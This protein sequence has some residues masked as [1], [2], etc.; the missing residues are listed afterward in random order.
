VTS[1]LVELLLVCLTLGVTVAIDSLQTSRLAAELRERLPA[2][3]ARWAAELAAGAGATAPQGVEALPV[4]RWALFGAAVMD[5]ESQGATSAG[6]APK[7]EWNGTGDGGHAVTPWQIDVRYHAAY[8]AKTG[9][10]R[11][12]DSIYAFG[13]LARG[14]AAATS[15]GAQLEEALQLAAAAYNAGHKPLDAWLASG[16]LDAAD[17]LT[18]GHNYG[19]DVLRRLETI[20]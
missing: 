12:S 9:R 18:T 6:Y 2:H 4:G 15:A 13:I 19:A 17:A 14:Y 1:A 7:G 5:R 10:T 8:L 20:S 16:A 3:L 11:A